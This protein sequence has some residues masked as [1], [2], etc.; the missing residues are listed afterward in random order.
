N[1]L[2]ARLARQ[3]PQTNDGIGAEV[4]PLADDL[5]AQV[6]TPLY[7]LLAAV[8]AMLLI[9][10]AN[11]V[12]LLVARSLARDRELAVRVALGASRRRL[13]VQSMVEIVPLVAGGGALGLMAA[14]WTLQALIPLLPA[15]VPRV[16]EI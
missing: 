3:S 9:G 15:D 4:V 2:A 11:L 6:R 8:A 12:N 10:C 13:V 16:E 5:V 7:G 14:R 1:A